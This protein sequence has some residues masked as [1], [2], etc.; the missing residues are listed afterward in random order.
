MT[1][2]S[3]ASQASPKPPLSGRA[4]VS[5][6]AIP[7]LSRHYL[8][9]WFGRFIDHDPLADRLR[10]R[11]YQPRFRPGLFVLAVR[12]LHPQATALLRKRSSQPRPVPD[13]R[14]VESDEGMTGLQVKETGLWFSIHAE[15]DKTCQTAPAMKDWEKFTLLTE[16][17]LDG[18]DLLGDPE[19]GECRDPSGEAVPAFVMDESL[20]R[21]S[22]RLGAKVFTP[23]LNLD[24]LEELGQMAPGEVKTLPFRLSDPDSDH[25]GEHLFTVTR[26]E[27]AGDGAP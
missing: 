25:V 21:S 10:R 19:L 6:T 1:L 27:P 22:G 12:P 18:L 24:L 9:D 17:M 14:M 8:L 26:R 13:F 4:E 15:N 7:S 3:T 20:G 2:P 11:P 23:A 5:S 16:T